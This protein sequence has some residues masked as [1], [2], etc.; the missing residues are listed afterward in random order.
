VMFLMRSRII[1]KVMHWLTM[2]FCI[3]QNCAGDE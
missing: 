2:P 1:W 3:F